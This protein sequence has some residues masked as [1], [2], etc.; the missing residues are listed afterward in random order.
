MDLFIV[1]KLTTHLLHFDLKK[2]VSQSHIVINSWGLADISE[3]QCLEKKYI[4]M[5]SFK[6]CLKNL[7]HSLKCKERKREVEIILSFD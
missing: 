3:S 1:N 7:A 2:Y 6:I 4:Y 5:S